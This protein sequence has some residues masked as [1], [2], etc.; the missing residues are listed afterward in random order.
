[1]FTGVTQ[2]YHGVY[3]YNQWRIELWM[4]SWQHLFLTSN[5]PCKRKRWIL[6]GRSICSK[7]VLFAS[8]RRLT[9]KIQGAKKLTQGFPDA[10]G[11]RLKVN[12]PSLRKEK[13]LFCFVLF[14]CFVVVCLSF[15][16]QFSV[17]PNEI[18]YFQMLT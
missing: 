18:N 12:I 15:C 4:E 5:A 10:F 14:Y 11:A 7:K 3:I 6:A 8:M 2:G 17:K 13:V 9:Y 1:M 16:C